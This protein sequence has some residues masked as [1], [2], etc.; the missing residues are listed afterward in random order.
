MATLQKKINVGSDAANPLFKPLAELFSALPSEK[1]VVGLSGGADS[2]M[3][4]L[5]ASHI[6]PQYAIRLR[7]LHIHHGLMPDADQWAGHC[8]ELARHLDIPCEVRQAKVD[9]KSGLGIEGAARQARYQCYSDYAVATNTRHFLL[10]HHLNDQAETLLL[11]LLRGTGV[12]GMRGMQADTERQGLILHRPWLSVDRKAIIALAEAFEKETH[13]AYINDESNTDIK[14]KRGA[15]RQL[16]VPSLDQVWPSWKQNLSRYGRLM[17][18]AQAIIDDMAALDFDRIDGQLHPANFCLK[19][20][21]ALPIYRQSNVV[22][23]W[24]ALAN[25]PMPSEKRLQAWLKQFRQVH[26]LGFDRDVTLAHENWVIRVSK[27]RVVIGHAEG[28]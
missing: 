15:V 20:W 26:Q 9:L 27:G 14:Y 5:C 17:G 3:L 10:A 22:R 18:E 7:F 2:A 21:R 28:A 25:I 4:A 1:V 6:A 11:R 16:L 13:W 23:Y 12:Q 8:L 24:L 19:Q